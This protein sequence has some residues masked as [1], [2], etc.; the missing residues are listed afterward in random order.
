[1]RKRFAYLL[2]AAFAA[3]S[4]A[5]AR[6]AILA[7][8]VADF[9]STVQGT[10][11]GTPGSGTPGTY[12]YGGIEFPYSNATGNA[13]TADP[14][15][16]GTFYP[17]VANGAQ[18]NGT[19]AYCCGGNFPILWDTGGHGYTNGG[20]EG[21]TPLGTAEAPD[22][23]WTSNY[24]GY[25]TISGSYRSENACCDS[26]QRPSVYVGSTQYLLSPIGQA[27]GETRVPGSPDPGYFPTHTYSISVPITVG[28]NISWVM[29]PGYNYYGNAF[30][31]TGL[32]T[33]PE[34]ASFAI[35]GAVIAGGM[36]VAR[37]R[38]A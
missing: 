27:N 23:V 18:W 33:V 32:V 17:L 28:E 19:V 12:T 24:N 35:W 4:P 15:N 34:P 11:N 13:E 30:M 36:L 10:Y 8:T 16:T 21:N 31:F 29:N 2:L 6:A 7:N 14:L 3:S 20:G 26:G 22:R 25:V 1:M 9:Q 38:N 5:F 37:R